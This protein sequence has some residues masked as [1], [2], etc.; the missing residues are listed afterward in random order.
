MLGP[1]GDHQET[2]EAERHPGAGRET[3]VESCEERFI[4]RK[5]G[6]TACLSVTVGLLEAPPLF[7]PVA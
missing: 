1:R 2:V 3:G 4:D 7:N 5:G 6:A